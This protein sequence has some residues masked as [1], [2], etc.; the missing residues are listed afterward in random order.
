M[1][2]QLILSTYMKWTN[3]L[4]DTI[5]IFSTEKLQAQVESLVVESI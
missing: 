4:K 1:W 3:V 5:K 2:C